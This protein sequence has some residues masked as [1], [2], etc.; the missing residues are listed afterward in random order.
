MTFNRYVLIRL[1]TE[2]LGAAACLTSI[3][4]F[5]S[6]TGVVVTVVVTVIWLAAEI[7]A[8]V[9]FDKKRPRRDELSTEHQL[10][11]TRFAFFVGVGAL[12]AV[13]F[14]WTVAPLAVR[15]PVALNPMLLPALAMGIMAVSDARYL[16]LETG[17]HDNEER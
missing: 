6:M 4:A 16:W 12:I 14:I 10:R 8:S 3:T 15:H 1:V 9:M 13:G 17:D 2:I 7:T 5:S 11:S